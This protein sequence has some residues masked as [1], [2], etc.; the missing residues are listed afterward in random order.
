MRPTWPVTTLDRLGVDRKEGTV[1]I[2]KKN[3]SSRIQ[4]DDGFI[5][6]QTLKCGHENWHPSEG[7]HQLGEWH[8]QQQDESRWEDN[9]KSYFFR[10]WQQMY[11]TK[12]NDDLRTEKESINEPQDLLNYFTSFW[13][14]VIQ[15]EPWLARCFCCYRATDNFDLD[16]SHF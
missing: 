14:S 4:S 6:N 1:E 7:L 16:L 3:A 9:N 12:L 10:I 11:N 13:E 15:C 5:V 8:S 2:N